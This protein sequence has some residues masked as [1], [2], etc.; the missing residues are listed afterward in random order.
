[1]LNVAGVKFIIKHA[2][3]GT[4]FI[5]NCKFFTLGE[6]EVSSIHEKKQAFFENGDLNGLSWLKGYTHTSSQFK[7]KLPLHNL[8]G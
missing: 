8:K 1:M 7:D 6:R 2:E 5:R 4:P 3:N